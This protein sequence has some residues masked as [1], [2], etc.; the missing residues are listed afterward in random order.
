[1]RAFERG[2]PHD[3]E[4]R[5]RRPSSHRSQSTSDPGVAVSALLSAQT[6]VIAGRKAED[7]RSCRYSSIAQLP[8][9]ANRHLTTDVNGTAMQHDWL[10]NRRFRLGEL[11]GQLSQVH[12]FE[13]GDV[14]STGTPAGVGVARYQQ[15]FLHDGDE[16]VVSLRGIGELCNPVTFA[17]RTMRCLHTA[18]PVRGLG[19]LLSTEGKR[20]LS[21]DA[22]RGATRSGR[23][24]RARR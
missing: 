13:P 24:A 18:R 2:A 22:E 20:L 14:V 11:R 3:V 8:D 19:P 15:V 7:R 1:M 23:E 5:P 4:N 17:P 6:P 9:I 16:N 12:A 10:G 21:A